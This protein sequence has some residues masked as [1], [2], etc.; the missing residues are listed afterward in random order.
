MTP[1]PRIM[2]CASQ[3]DLQLIASFALSLDDLRSFSWLTLCSDAQQVRQELQDSPLY[4]EVWV[5]SSSEVEGINLAAALKFDT[6]ERLVCLVESS[7]TDTGRAHAR[8][9]GIDQVL[10]LE[11]LVWR[12][13]TFPAGL[14]AS[15][16]GASGNPL[17]DENLES[18]EAP[19]FSVAPSPEGQSLSTDL[20]DPSGFEML[21]EEQESI[22][23]GTEPAEAAG[24]EETMSTVV[25]HREETAPTVVTRQDKLPLSLGA[26][27]SSQ[28]RDARK[29]YVLSVLS[30]SGG[31]GKST[32]ATLVA[33]LAGRRGLRTALVDADF[34]FGDLIFMAS[35]FFQVPA[36]T[37]LEDPAVLDA[38]DGQASVLVTAPS[39]LEQAEALAPR[40]GELLTALAERFDLIVVNTGGPWGEAHAYLL[41]ASMTTLLLVDQRASSIRAC[42]RALDLCLRCGIAT[43]SFLIALNR[44][45]KQALFTPADVSEALN[46]ARVIELCEGGSET[47]EMLSAGQL[48]EYVS[49]AGPLCVSADRLIDELSLPAI[50]AFEER[51]PLRGKSSWGRPGKSSRSGRRRGSRKARSAK[52][53]PVLQPIPMAPISG[54]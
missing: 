39:R 43:S 17:P 6:P 16:S 41:E 13:E 37:L 9:A 53:A 31:T 14:T 50:R 33:A 20:P 7:P 22:W 46:G 2:L 28:A 35:S 51:D 42:R 52:K 4:Q 21:E 23:A 8:L 11:E 45:G 12:C 5:L 3:E 29:G 30:G 32:V 48:D 15:C 36:E 27:A 47:E 44:C 26:D 38:A 1:E 25:P 18:E 40:I 54:Q 34:Q 19:L 24:Q 49:E 10:S